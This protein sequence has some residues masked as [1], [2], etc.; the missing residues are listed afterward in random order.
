MWCPLQSRQYV[1]VMTH[2][3]CLQHCHSTPSRA[4]LILP[5]SF[6]IH[7]T[8]T[9]T[10]TRT[11]F[12]FH[13]PVRVGFLQHY[14]PL[15]YWFSL[16]WQCPQPRQSGFVGTSVAQRTK[17]GITL[18]EGERQSERQKSI[19]ILPATVLPSQPFLSSAVV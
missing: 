6:R 7:H 11:V 12:Y 16:M 8:N 3:P 15:I 13:P 9:H 19:T 14:I 18:N 4:G 10:L 2:L 5:A 17:S 1:R